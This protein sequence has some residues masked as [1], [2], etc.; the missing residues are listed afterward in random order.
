M[1]NGDR[2]DQ[3]CLYWAERRKKFAKQRIISLKDLS[4]RIPQKLDFEKE[5]SITEIPYVEFPNSH[6]SAK[7]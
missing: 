5:V 6:F 1:M 3:L 4:G 2:L 7:E